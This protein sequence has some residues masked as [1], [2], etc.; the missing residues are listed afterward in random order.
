MRIFFD[1]DLTLLYS[2]GNSWALRPG[3]RE[4]FSRVRALGHTIYLWSATGK[5]HAERLVRTYGLE[6]WV[7]ECLDKDSDCPVKP[8]MIVDDDR[9]L[10]EKYS[11]VWVKPY[12][13]PDPSDREL[14]RVLEALDGKGPESPNGT[15]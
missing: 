14:F 5:P 11:G 1:V 2:V 13:D 10:V 8:D 12:R 7:E 3:V 15:G 9:Y 4:V 6:A